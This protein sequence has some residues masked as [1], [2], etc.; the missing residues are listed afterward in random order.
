MENKHLMKLRYV[1]QWENKVY[2]SKFYTIIFH[3]VAHLLQDNITFK[4]RENR[5]SYWHPEMGWKLCLSEYNC[6]TVLT[7]LLAA[8]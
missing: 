7:F 4:K 8:L 5:S 6:S 2:L 1:I 3:F